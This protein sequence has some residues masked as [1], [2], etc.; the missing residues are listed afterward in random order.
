MKGFDIMK[1]SNK[2]SVDVWNL[3][4]VFIKYD[5]FNDNPE[6]SAER[7]IAYGVLADVYSA[8]SLN[9]KEELRYLYYHS[10]ALRK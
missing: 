1:I 3:A 7:D 10:K 2:N 8:L 6:M 4:K 9:A 5:F